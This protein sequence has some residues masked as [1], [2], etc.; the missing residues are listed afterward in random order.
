MPAPIVAGDNKTVDFDMTRP[1]YI[2]K[3]SPA[4]REALEEFKKKNAEVTAANAKIENLNKLLK[5]ARTDTTAGNL[6]LGGEG[7][8][9]CD[10]GQA[11]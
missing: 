10:H 5:T 1:E 11:G 8:D 9:R 7:H 2:A 4:D 6:R 3:M